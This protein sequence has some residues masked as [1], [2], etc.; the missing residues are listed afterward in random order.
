MICSVLHN[1]VRRGYKNAFKGWGVMSKLE[2]LIGGRMDEMP[3][4]HCGAE[5]RLNGSVKRSDETE[6]RLY[7]CAV[8]GRELR[9]TV[10]S[11]TEVS[12]GASTGI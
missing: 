2:R 8:C 9:L 3:D 1:L 7:E 11:D 4:C 5:M 12:T 10:W 6:M